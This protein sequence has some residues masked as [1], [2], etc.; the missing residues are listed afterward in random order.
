[1]TRE[2]IIRRQLETGLPPEWITD[3]LIEA[4]AY[5]L[6]NGFINSAIEYAEPRHAIALVKY[7]GKIKEASDE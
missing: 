7:A 4:V 5:A 3:D 1:M 6:G 2:E